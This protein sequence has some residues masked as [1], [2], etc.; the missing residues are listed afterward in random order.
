MASKYLRKLFTTCAIH[1]YTVVLLLSSFACG[2]SMPCVTVPNN[3]DSLSS[4]PKLSSPEE[5]QLPIW[6]RAL[7][8]DLPQTTA[9]MLELDYK[10]R[11]VP[12]DQLRLYALARLAV[13]QV[14]QCDYGIAYASLDLKR[15][16]ADDL[17][18]TATQSPESLT[19]LEKRV[20]DFARQMTIAGRD[21]TDEQVASL[22][23][24]LGPDL[25]VGL[26]LNIGYT[27][28]QN[29]LVLALNLSI[30]ADGPLEP[31]HWKFADSTPSG[32]NTISAHRD[33]MPEN[34]PSKQT[35]LATQSWR[36]LPFESLQTNLENQRER[37]PRIA[38]P[39]WEEIKP[40]L[41][42]GLYPK[43]LRIRWSRVVVGYQPVVGPAW[44]KCLRVFEQE[45]HQN[46]VFEESIFWIV[47]RGLRC[48][49]C[50][51]HCEMLMQEGGL[52]RGQI[53]D[54]TARLASG[55]WQSFSP[56]EQAAFQ[57]A[58][59]LGN[60]PSEMQCTDFET[61]KTALGPQRAIDCVWWSS[62]CH[63]MTKVSDAFQLQLERE[64]VFI[65]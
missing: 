36:D 35:D 34:T 1:A 23:E 15:A 41:P 46:R 64:N 45:A 17:L 55:N 39:D 56:A 49:Y 44:I 32:A 30:E 20:Y 5:G 4:L 61:L 18:K 47:T 63:F 31:T 42:E 33:A 65:D 27:N 51:G 28:F 57:F 58:Y 13:S 54:R 14:H 8:H 62:R 10:V 59:K 43:P 19:D 26:V 25:L 16:N 12:S 21:A 7:A 2:Q 37:K 22:Q 48:Y 24:A 3:Q 53:A 38:V 50:M 11:S 29:R 40:R 52:D 9:A 6:A 60:T